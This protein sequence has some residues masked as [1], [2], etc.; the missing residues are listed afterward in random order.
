MKNSLIIF[1]F[2]FL[3]FSCEKDDFCTSDVKTPKLIL[4]FKDSQDTLKFKKTKSLYV[5]AEGKDTLYNKVIVDSIILPLNPLTNETVYN[6]SENNSVDKLKINYSIKEEFIS[7]SCG[8]RLIYN[9]VSLSVLPTK[10]WINTISKSKIKIINK[11]EDA[12]ITVYY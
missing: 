4:K 11:Q 10:L 5:W 8:Y 2:I 7:R 6:L 9:D 1:G 3:L 12:Q